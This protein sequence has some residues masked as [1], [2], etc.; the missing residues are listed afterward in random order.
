MEEKIEKI[1]L[2]GYQEMEVVKQ[3]DPSH[4]CVPTGC[5]WMIRYKKLLRDDDLIKF[6]EEFNLFEKGGNTF[7]NVAEAIQRKYQ[8]IHI[9]THDF[10][11]DDAGLE[12]IEF[13]KSL[14]RVQSPCLISVATKEGGGTNWHIMPVVGLDDEQKVLV[15]Y[16]PENKDINKNYEGK[17]YSDIIKI[18][19]EELG[20]KDIAWIPK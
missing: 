8:D 16:H 5:E 18:H 2:L 11:K 9:E 17:S 10:K 12:K 1:F 15:L 6:Q 19:K 14:I 4:G 7:K 3:R 13:I 20:G